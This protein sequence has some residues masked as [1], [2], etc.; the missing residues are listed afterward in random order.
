MSVR[1]DRVRC[2]VTNTYLVR[3]H[4]VILV[5][6][7]DPRSGHRVL[8]KLAGVLDDPRSIRLMVGTH[9][10]F[11]HVG[12]AAELR[13]ATDA[14]LAVHRGDVGWV[15]SGTFQWPAGV[16][17]WGTFV[18]RF[19]GPLMIPFMRFRPT[20]VDVELGD[21]GLDLAPYGVTGRVVHTP[22][23]S[24]GSVSV[25]LASGEALVGDLAMNGPPMCLK[26]SYGVF[27]H[28][29]ELVSASWR[30]LLDLGART[31][32]PAHGRPF[33]ATALATR[34]MCC[35]SGGASAPPGHAG[36]RPTPP[37]RP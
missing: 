4:G 35:G 14:A 23:H 26:P 9:G 21:E 2:G 37:A 16:T 29:P 36:P 3:E 31:V 1:I 33:P 13:R 28:Q 6:P 7:G 15:R 12:A 22:G 11:D 19:L 5:D 20:E 8:R 25:L 32:Y 10:H 24:P 27:A 18:R 30:R 17:P 34:Q